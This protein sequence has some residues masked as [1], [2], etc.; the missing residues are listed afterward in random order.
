[1]ADFEIPLN[2]YPERFNITL[3][4]QDLVLQTSWS[5]INKTWSL[6]IRRPDESTVLAGLPLIPGVDLLAQHQH[7]G[8]G[9]S[10]YAK[11]DH[12]NHEVPGFADLGTTGHLYFV[13]P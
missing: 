3:G 13:T 4:A 11:V 9:G 5:E 12:S 7:L 10:L 6:T 1:M 2:P 8:L